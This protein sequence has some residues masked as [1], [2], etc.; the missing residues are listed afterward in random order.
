[1][2]AWGHTSRHLQLHDHRV[3]KLLFPRIS[4]A[5]LLSTT[6][7]Q[8]NDSRDGLQNVSS[9]LKAYCHVA[10]IGG[11]NAYLRALKSAVPPML[12]ALITFGQVWLT[13]DLLLTTG[14]ARLRQAF[15]GLARLGNSPIRI[16]WD[17]LDDFRAV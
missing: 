7:F 8:R 1:M 12:L 6:F 16:D 3:N 13:L 11:Q 17:A 2:P 9:K 14:K 10:T 5:S 4:R 15:P